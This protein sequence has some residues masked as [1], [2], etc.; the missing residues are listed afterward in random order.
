VKVSKRMLDD[1]MVRRL[2]DDLREVVGGFP[3]R[4]VVQEDIETLPPDAPELALAALIDKYRQARELRLSTESRRTQT[5]SGLLISRLQQ[6]L[7][8]SIEAFARTL[9]VHRKTVLR[10][11]EELNGK[12]KPIASTFSSDLLGGTVDAD[13][14]R[15]LLSEHDFQ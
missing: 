11:W 9:R 3:R 13:D 1:V 2:K 10:Q 14:D 4:E 6:R 15:A 12:N 5:A 7:F 8:S